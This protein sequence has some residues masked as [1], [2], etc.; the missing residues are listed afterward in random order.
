M[1]R[2]LHQNPELS[3]EEKETSLFIKK[4][5]KDAGI[6]FTDGW[7][8]HGIVAEVKGLK[9]QGNSIALRADMDALPIKET[10]KKSY[11]ST[12][13]GIMHAC[14][15][16]VHTA[17]LIGVAQLL[18]E[19]RSG[20][21]GTV[22]FIFQPGEEKLPGGAS[23]MIKEGVFKKNKVKS[24][25]GQHV[26]PPLQV[27]KVGIR[28]GVYMASADE[29]YFSIKGKGGHAALP[30]NCIDP[31]LV[32]SKIITNLQD[33]ISRKKNPLSPSVL[34]IGKINSV[35]GATNIIPNEVLLEGTFR[36][37]DEKWRFK[38]HKEIIKIARRT[39]AAF[40][41]KCEVE[42]KVGYPC[43]IN[44]A[45]YTAFIK[46]RMIEYMGKSNVVELPQRM[47]AEDFAYYS[48]LMPSCFYRLGT[49]NKSKGIVS[50]V[51]TSDFDIDES[52][53]GHSSGLMAYLAI[54]SL[55]Y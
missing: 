54:A 25:L 18:Q 50:P 33:V 17:S 49:G 12:N 29:L 1:R 30:H 38:A 47:S 35:G 23:L 19:N 6:K 55:S 52:A 41:A 2:K 48:Q 22:K 3:F 42:I 7:V 15:H 45:K 32:A 9:G 14:G 43:L 53:F 4:E 40:G 24:I 28:S 5:L 11:R 27:G 37:M 8:K 20:F 31:I 26:H 16:D 34:S 10:N 39:A 44:D 13:P 21:A 46:E 36:S 51:H